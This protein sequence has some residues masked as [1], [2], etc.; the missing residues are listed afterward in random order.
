MKST[1][2]DEDDTMSIQSEVTNASFGISSD[3]WNY[4]KHG[5]PV[6]SR[7]ASRTTSPSTTL[8]TV[9]QQNEE[10]TE[11]LMRVEAIAVVALA[12]LP[13]SRSLANRAEANAKATVAK[14]SDVNYNQ[15]SNMTDSEIEN[16]VRDNIDFDAMH[17]GETGV[18][19]YY[20]IL[21]D[22]VWI[23]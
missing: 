5:T 14:E 1:P 9:L 6:S 12:Q 19:D 22:H 7:P 23:I 18:F 13:Y 4:S 15:L 2:E 16:L 20:Q 10:L 21:T 8:K 17:R 3:H 11:R